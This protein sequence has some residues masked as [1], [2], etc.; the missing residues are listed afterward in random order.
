MT[1]GKKE[2]STYSHIKT[3]ANTATEKDLTVVLP[4]FRGSPI[5]IGCEIE[6]LR[7]NGYGKLAHSKKLGE[8]LFIKAISAIIFKGHNNFLT[9]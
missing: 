3:I 1:T 6:V 8:V 7:D 4:E 5:T 9:G 2:D